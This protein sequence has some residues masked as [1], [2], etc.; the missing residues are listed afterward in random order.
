[1]SSAN[2]YFELKRSRQAR[3]WM[4]ETINER[5]RANFYNDEQVQ[6]MLAEAESRVLAN[7]QTSFAAASQVLAAYYGHPAD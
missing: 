2:G 7:R 4:Y 5:L 3:Y 1:M 6:R